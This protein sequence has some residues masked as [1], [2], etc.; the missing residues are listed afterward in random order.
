MA[1]GPAF[2]VVIPEAAQ[3]EFKLGSKEMDKKRWEEAKDHFQ[4]AITAFPKYA[5]A[6]NESWTGGNPTEGRQGRRGGV[7]Q[8]HPD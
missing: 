6:F 2:T 3:K 7:S 5:E 8:R 1:P 4:K